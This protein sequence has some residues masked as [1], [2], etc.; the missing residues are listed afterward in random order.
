MQKIPL[1]IYVA[2]NNP[3]GAAA[4]INRFN[5]MPP[6]N[7]HDLIRGLRHV[8]LTKGEEG[9]REIAKIHPDKQL[10]LDAHNIEPEIKSNACGCH[11]NANGEELDNSLLSNFLTKDD[12]QKYEVEK[13]LNQLKESAILTKDDIATEVKKAL[14][15]KN[16]FISNTLP[17]IALLGV[18]MFL[19]T[20]IIKNH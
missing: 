18:S 3:S 9:F 20:S 13:K 12:L 2:T 17:Y 11:S 10:I 16:Q 14:N 7:D 6:K 15:D 4:I 8:M 5:L 19:F 1:Y